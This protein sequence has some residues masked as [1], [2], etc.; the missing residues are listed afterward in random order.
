[1]TVEPPVAGHDDELVILWRRHPADLARAVAAG[2][3]FAATMGLAAA[4]PGT[5][6]TLSDDVIGLL[7]HLPPT[8]RNVIGGVAQLL[9]L[10]L[11]L[12]L[13]GWAARRRQ[14]R[15]LSIAA[16]AGVAAALVMSSLIDWFDRVAPPRVSVNADTESL[17]FG[18]EFP[19][20]S[21]VAALAAATVVIAP[22]LSHRWRR[23]AWIGVFGAALLRMASAA[24]VP[25]NVGAAVALGA[26]IGSLILY[27]AGAPTRQLPTDRVRSALR[28]LGL[29]VSTLDRRDGA[30]GRSFDAATER[31]PALV[32]W[33]GRDDRDAD[34]LY[35]AWRSLRVRG[36]EAELAAVAPGHQVRAEALATYIAG[37]AGVSTPDVLALGDTDDDGAIIAVAGR[38]G[39]AL[40]DLD[41]EELT[42]ELLDRVWQLVAHLRERRLAHG[43]L[44]AGRIRV[45]A[46][47]GTVSIENLRWAHVAAD[48]FHL[49]A[50]GAEML[51]SLAGIVGPERAVRSSAVLGIETQRSVLPLVQPLALS[52]PTRRAARK[53][54]GRIEAVQT[55]LAEATGTEEVELQPIERVGISSIVSLAGFLF[56]LFVIIEIAGSWSEISDQLNQ[57]DLTYLPTIIAL[58]AGTYVAGAFT[59]SGAV[60]RPL[61][62]LPTTI[63]MVAQSFL[64]R[65]TP[66]NAGGMAMRVRYLQKGGSELTAAITSLGLTTAVV[67]VI[68]VPL[69]AV[70]FLWAQSSPG[71]TFGGPSVSTVAFVS[72]AVFA[73]AAVV[74]FVPRIRAVVQPWLAL[75]WVKT[76]DQFRSL[77]TSPSKMLLL[78]GGALATKLL[79]ITAFVESCW[80]LGIDLGYAELGALYLIGSTVGA[81]VPTPGGL[82]AIEAALIAALTSADVAGPTATAAVILF[83]LITYWLPVPF[84]YAATR[85]ARHQELV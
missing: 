50:D 71:G 68:Q 47:D 29:K 84:G 22:L 43:S 21:Y 13:V 30:D 42:D 38:T 45:D 49:A 7:V 39:V 59:L 75:T 56:L 1:M 2:L 77:A 69:M 46:D 54:N 62:L 66:A 55:A 37:D 6:T 14:P 67:P 60:V 51:V 72:F 8:L 31:G 73:V 44:T 32:R 57:V 25:V 27:A 70:F 48:D 16:L 81:A 24:V 5:L 9:T 41:E 74:F 23:A 61:A 35:Q 10:L 52:A 17:L 65:F 26:T 63:V 80:A 3:L 28:R 36:A 33:V 15:V 58:T 79:T 78:F 34:L 83:R 82:G 18:L 19:S 12:A 64:N 85:L 20:A 4:R 53:D 76:I 11:P 40:T